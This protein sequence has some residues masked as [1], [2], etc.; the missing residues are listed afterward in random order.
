VR[1]QQIQQR[2]LVERR[3]EF[4]EA[5]GFEEQVFDAA[6]GHGEGVVGEDELEQRTGSDDRYRPDPL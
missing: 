5:H 6:H 3:E 1:S 4:L 2:R